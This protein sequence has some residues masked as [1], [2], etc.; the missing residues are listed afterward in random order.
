MLVSAEAASALQ[1]RVTSDELARVVDSV[2]ARAVADGLVPALGVAVTM[3]GLTLLA[4]SHGMADAT[5]GVAADDRTLWYLASTSKSLTGFGVSLLAHDGVIS[6]DAPI[7]SLIRAARWHPDA[8]PDRLTLGHFLSHTHHLNDAVVVTNAAFTGAVPESEWPG[9]LAYANPTGS[10]DLVYTN[11][12]YNVA[13]MVID[14]ARPA[15]WRRFLEDHVY[16]PAGMTETYARVSGFDAR[17]IA[18]PHRLGADGHYTTEPFL[19][20]DVT[21]NAAGGH[22]A[23]LHDLARWTIVQMDSGSIDGRQVFPAA[24]VAL[25]HRL[26]AP[27]TR[28]QSKRFGYFD[29]EGWGAGWDIGAYD[30]ERMVGRFGS[31]AGTQSRLGFLPSRRVGAVAMAT[32]GLAGPVSDVLLTLAFDLGTGRT[33]AVTRAGERMEQLGGRLTQSLRSI[34]ANDSTR[35]ERQKQVLR[36]PLAQFAGTFARPGLGEVSFSQ[37]GNRLQLR[38]GAI[39]SDVEIFEA[40]RN[41]MRFEIAGSGTVAQFEFG[42][43]GPATAVII[44]GSR[45]ERRR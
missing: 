26:I 32:G 22:L 7:A 20:T 6:F 10:T 12:G 3:N 31:Y 36:H 13:A 30:G 40:S 17:R 38:W 5:G 16:R 24:A 15:G 35:A 8:N 14:A 37:R 33:D 27:Q 1:G 25:S 39:T 2:A 42:P 21:M 34:A 28:D 19:K 11:L 18:R 41:Q 23:T 43:T 29:R 9:L 4:R 44:Q 45:F